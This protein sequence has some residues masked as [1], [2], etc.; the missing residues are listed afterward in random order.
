MQFI[1]RFVIGIIEGMFIWASTNRPN[2]KCPRRAQPQGLPNNVVPHGTRRIDEAGTTLGVEKSE[3]EKSKRYI[4]LKP[5]YWVSVQ[6]RQQHFL[7]CVE[8][9][10]ADNYLILL[11]Q[12]TKF[13]LYFIGWPMKWMIAFIFVPYHWYCCCKFDHCGLYDEGE[14]HRVAEKIS[15]VNERYPYK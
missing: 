11:L 1:R 12:H 6:P 7:E 4:V 14:E 2:S 3:V 5:E 13:L 15:I 10:W 9:W 8:S